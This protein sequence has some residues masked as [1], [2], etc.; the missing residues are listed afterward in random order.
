MG[1]QFQY[2]LKLVSITVPKIVP[3]KH[4]NDQLP[5][6]HGTKTQH[7]KYKKKLGIK[8]QKHGKYLCLL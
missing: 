6:Q 5:S 4:S 3:P 2:N 1:Y 7:V 8:H